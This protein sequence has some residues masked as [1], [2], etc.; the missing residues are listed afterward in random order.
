MPITEFGAWTPDKPD[1]QNPGLIDAVNVVP[2]SGGYRPFLGPT[3]VSTNTITATCR[4]AISFIDSIGVSQGYAGTSGKLFGL[5][6]LTHIDMSRASGYSLGEENTWDFDKFNEFVIAANGV[7]A[8]QSL[9][10]GALTF[11]DITAAPVAHH[12][13]VVGSFLVAGATDN[14]NTRIHWSAAGNPLD[15]PL[16]G[17]VTADSVQSGARVLNTLGGP[18]QAIVGGETGVVMQEKAISTMR[19]V[20]GSVVFQIENLPK[21]QGLLAKHAWI[22]VGN[23]VYFI[24]RDGFYAF[25]GTSAQPIGEDQVNN[26]FLTDV[27]S[28]FLYRIQA[29]TDPNDNTIIFNYPNTSSSGAP[30]AQ[31]IYNYSTQRWARAT[32]SNTWMF[33]AFGRGLSLDNMDSEVTSDLDA[34]PL[35]LDSATYNRG[36]PVLSGYN[37]SHQLTDYSGTALTATII[38][39]EMVGPGHMR[40][41]V[42][43]TVPLVE[44]SAVAVE[45]G[46]RDTQNDSVTY[47]ASATANADG[48]SYS[49]AEGRYVRPRFTIHNLTLAYGYD[50]MLRP[51]GRY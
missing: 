45:I 21:V 49:E 43:Y 5:Q 51:A 14:D 2:G 33:A 35:S 28:S 37:S 9:A 36:N 4:G 19:Y 26:F 24:A 46:T 50:I 10:A 11:V 12:V 31:L 20:G 16:L 30:N 3:V 47:E 44:C 17:S 38:A 34:I 48:Y 42:E 40:S 13:S 6:G 32:D 18:I 41:T 8:M 7:D 39:P 22:K 15:W 27:N 29:T 1:L 25:D 23:I